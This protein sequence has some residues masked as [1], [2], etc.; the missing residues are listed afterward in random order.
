MQATDSLNHISPVKDV[1]KYDAHVVLL[2]NPE[3]AGQELLRLGF[4]RFEIIDSSFSQTPQALFSKCENSE[5]D[6]A[7]TFLRA[8]KIVEK[9]IALVETEMVGNAEWV[10]SPNNTEYKRIYTLERVDRSRDS[11][12]HFGDIHLDFIL[13]SSS[14]NL[15]NTYSKIGYSYLSY[16]EDNVKY[17][18][19]TAQFADRA[20]YKALRNNMLDIYSAYPNMIKAEF[21]FEKLIGY[22][23]F[24]G[25]E[26]LPL[27]TGISDA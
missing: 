22:N 23:T 6:L 5:S 26:A 10:R 19:V 20:D 17:A 14:T 13:D 25:M 21:R 7:G 16:I 1:S 15:L 24:N 27:I 12:L 18:S 4:E 8:S 11:K 9:E 3:K 2:E